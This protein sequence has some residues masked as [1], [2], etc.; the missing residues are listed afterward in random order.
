MGSRARSKKSN[1]A[2]KRAATSRKPAADTKAPPVR[3]VSGA[4]FVLVPKNGKP[5]EMMADPMKM[6]EPPLT[7]DA[8]QAK[9]LHGRGSAHKFFARNPTMAKKFN[10][11]RVA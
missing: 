1:A 2:A 4:P 3:K 11:Q 5:G 7:T 10:A 9:I 6:Q 8:A